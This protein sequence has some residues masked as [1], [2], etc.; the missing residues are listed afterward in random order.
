MEAVALPSWEIPA[1]RTGDGVEAWPR[2]ITREAW[3]ACWRRGQTQAQALWD[4]SGLQVR[5]VGVVACELQV[6]VQFAF[7]DADHQ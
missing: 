1:V 3:A 6:E 5:F 7:A 4:R 2:G